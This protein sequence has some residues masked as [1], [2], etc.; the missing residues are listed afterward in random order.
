[1]WAFQ[2]QIFQKKSTVRIPV[3]QNRADRKVFENARNK[4]KFHFES[5]EAAAAGEKRNPN[6]FSDSLIFG[7]G[8]KTFSPNTLDNNIGHEQ[9]NENTIYFIERF[10]SLNFIDFFSNNRQR[11]HFYELNFESHLNQT[12]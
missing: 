5:D 3:C 7:E 8:N 9:H 11:G 1:M 6:T 10:M 12:F 4:H 2:V